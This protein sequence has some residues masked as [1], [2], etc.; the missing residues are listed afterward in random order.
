MNET[1]EKWEITIDAMMIIGKYFESN[2]DCI[3]TM[4]VA[5]RYHDLA[6]M[7]HFNPIQECELFVNMETQHFYK[8]EDVNKK[9][10]T[11][12]DKV[13]RRGNNSKKKGMRE[14]IYWYYVKKDEIENKKNNET[15]KRMGYVL[16]EDLVDYSNMLKEYVFTV[17]ED[18]IRI[19]E[20]C[21]EGRSGSFESIKLP[22][23][24]IS[25]E[26][27]AFYMSYIQSIVI[28]ERVTSKV[29]TVLVDAKIWKMF[30]YH[31]LY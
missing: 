15:Y 11:I 2:N 31:H 23:S 5:K 9:K 1:K 16:N 27:S 26:E 13:F 7:Y 24:L 19:G 8:K 30:N 20:R 22:L 10:H 12:L 6:K 28:P 3:N 18:V 21:F 4:K 29:N 17:P 25:I 14:Y